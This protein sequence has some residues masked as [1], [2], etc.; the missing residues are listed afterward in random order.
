MDKKD[1]I[2]E[3]LQDKDIV[4]E[5]L[6]DK[7]VVNKVPGLD[8][9]SK[10]AEEKKIGKEDPTKRVE[11]SPEKMEKKVEEPIKR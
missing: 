10:V 9:A 6:Q 5:K 11:T 3:K 7:D 1:I 8:A 2:P 4:P